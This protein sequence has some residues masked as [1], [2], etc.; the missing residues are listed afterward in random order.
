[1]QNPDRVGE[2]VLLQT[3]AVDAAEAAAADVDVGIVLIAADAGPAAVEAA[4]EAAENRDEEVD[5]SGLAAEAVELE[6]AVAAETEP[7]VAAAAVE[8]EPVVPAVVSAVGV[9]ELADAATVVEAAAAAFGVA[10]M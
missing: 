10:Q 6:P 4:V 2:L 8:P 3:V 5:G 1:M 7:A 9:E